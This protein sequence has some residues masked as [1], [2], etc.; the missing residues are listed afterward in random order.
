MLKCNTLLTQEEQRS[1]GQ[2]EQHQNPFDL[3]QRSGQASP[4]PSA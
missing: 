2:Q 4:V 3:R 1:Y